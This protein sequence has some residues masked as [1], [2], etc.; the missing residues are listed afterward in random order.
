MSVR[1][2]V[3]HVPKF[4]LKLR[5]VEIPKP[6]FI[7]VAP[8]K[9]KPIELL[10]VQS[11]REIRKHK[12]QIVPIGMITVGLLL[13]VSVLWPILFEDKELENGQAISP[14]VQQ[15]V[16]GVSSG[17]SSPQVLGVQTEGDRPK[18]VILNE[19]LDFTNLSAWFPDQVIPEIR[20]EEAHTYIIDIPALK[21]EQ[22]L[23]KVGGLNLDQNLIQYPGTSNPGES[24]S[25]VI[26]GHST[27]PIF[28]NPALNNPKRYT[29][30]FTRLMTLK[31]GDTINVRYDGVSYAYEVLD[32]KEIKPEDTTI[33]SQDSNDR[34]LKLVTC[35]P[36][37]TTLR[38]GVVT[39]RLKSVQ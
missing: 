5:K 25:P 32:K 23:V 2:Y 19:E 37:G 34:L 30:I 31:P 20:P 21:I 10:R 1:R 39:A 29:S 16:Q 28:Y 33:L 22:A 38:R 7:R 35:V 36:P 11:A 18:P 6:R 14:V 13:I 8:V 26:F 17:N 27:S 4:E 9:P 12:L 15:L 24:G 3:K